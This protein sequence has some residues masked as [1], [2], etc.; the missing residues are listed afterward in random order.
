MKRKNDFV[1]QTVGGENILVPLGTKVLD[2]NGLIT[3]NETAAHLW[4][5][6]SEH[7]TSDELA[8][9]LTN[10]FDINKKTANDDVQVFLKEI[11]KLDLLEE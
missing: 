1:M 6:L 10:E 9:A 7:H 11:N 8:S 5:L 3:L 2:L 4:Q